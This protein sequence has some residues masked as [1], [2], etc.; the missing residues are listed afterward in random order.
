M[1]FASMVGLLCY[2][3]YSPRDLYCRWTYKKDVDD[4]DADINMHV[5]RTTVHLAQLAADT[6]A[7]GHAHQIV[8]YASFLYYQIYMKPACTYRCYYIILC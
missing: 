8:K 1:W 6:I 5:T 7:I 4:A 2:S 3:P